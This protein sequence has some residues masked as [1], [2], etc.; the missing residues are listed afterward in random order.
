MKKKKSKEP[1]AKTILRRFL[2]PLSRFKHMEQDMG[3]HWDAIFAVDRHDVETF[4]ARSA[5][6]MPG[7]YYVAG[8]IKVQGIG[9]RDVNKGELFYVRIDSETGAA[10]VEHSISNQENVF[11]LTSSEWGAVRLKLQPVRLKTTRRNRR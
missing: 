2:A 1:A 9:P 5:F 10:D 11:S 6:R 7:L 3:Q 8:S 4:R